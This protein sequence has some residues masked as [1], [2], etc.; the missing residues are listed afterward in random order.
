METRIHLLLWNMKDD[1]S[2]MKLTAMKPL[3]N[4]SNTQIKHQLSNE[5]KLERKYS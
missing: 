2:L 3:Q 4:I 1:I 5:N